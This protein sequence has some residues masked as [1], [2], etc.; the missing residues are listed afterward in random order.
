MVRV[1]GAALQQ[2]VGLLPAVLTEVGVQQV[3]HRPE[4]AAF[5][6]VD[7]EQV[8]HVVERRRGVREQALLLDGR[9]LGVR[10]RDDQSTQPVAVLAG[11]LLPGGL[12]EVVTEADL[13]V[14]L[15]RGQEDAP[16][17]VGHLHVVEVRPAVA[18]HADRG[19]QVHL[20]R[21]EV[22]RPGVLPPLDVV[23][24]PALEGALQ[25]LVGGEVD[26][27]RDLL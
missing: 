1:A 27:V 24:L 20:V 3:H 11:H 15:V 9:G 22:G 7:L 10:L 19:P 17:V 25:A 5:L 6:H 21:V 2:L 26:V 14:V 23:R 12:T 4:V 13:A 18:V 16:A 8:A